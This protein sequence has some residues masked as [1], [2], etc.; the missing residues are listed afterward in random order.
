MRE[1]LQFAK[2]LFTKEKRAGFKNGPSHRITFHTS[3]VIVLQARRGKNT[4]S[5]NALIKRAP[6]FLQQSKEKRKYLIRIMVTPPFLVVVC[7]RPPVF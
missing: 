1:A 3:Q 7:V 2:N 4:P 5:V 6:R